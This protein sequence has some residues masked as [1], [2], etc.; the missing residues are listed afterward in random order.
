MNEST[1]YAMNET[2]YGRI[3]A[4][5]HALTTCISPSSAPDLRKA[6]DILRALDYW[7]RGQYVGRYL[8]ATLR[9]VIQE[10]ILY[11]A[12]SGQ[13]SICEALGDTLSMVMRRMGN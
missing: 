4:H 1:G 13:G 11:A 9:Y 8:L 12:Q 7:E 5:A 10:E 2:S 6:S 3:Y